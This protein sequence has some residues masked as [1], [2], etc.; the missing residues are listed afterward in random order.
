MAKEAGTLRRREAKHELF[1]LSTWGLDAESKPLCTAEWAVTP[2]GVV[3]SNWSMWHAHA[4]RLSLDF[5]SIGSSRVHQ[6]TL[7]TPGARQNVALASFI[8]PGQPLTLVVDIKLVSENHRTTVATMQSTQR[9][10]SPRRSLFDVQFN[11]TLQNTPPVMVTINNQ[12]GG[13]NMQHGVAIGLRCHCSSSDTWSSTINA[14]KQ[15]QTVFS[16]FDG[17]QAA[18]G[19]VMYE[20]DQPCGNWVHSCASIVVIWRVRGTCAQAYIIAA[21][22]Q[23]WKQPVLDAMLEIDIAPDVNHESENMDDY[24][25]TTRIVLDE[26][27]NSYMEAKFEWNEYQGLCLQVTFRYRNKV[28]DI[29]HDVIMM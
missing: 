28:S 19:L 9:A 18:A 1:F 10:I 26:E 25:K 7:G 27:D 5:C 17:E 21:E 20:L 8:L 12:L 14:G 22:Q 2:A 6:A 23:D 4:D 16:P 29:L 3:P 11:A 13:I 24:K 15:A